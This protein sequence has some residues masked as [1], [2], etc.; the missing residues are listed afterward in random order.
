[1]AKKKPKNTLAKMKA[2]AE[3]LWKAAK[4]AK[5]NRGKNYRDYVNSVNK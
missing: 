3:S 5:Q 4:D 1:M 2:N